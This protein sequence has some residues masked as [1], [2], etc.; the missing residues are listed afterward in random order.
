[1][2]F[3]MMTVKTAADAFMHVCNCL[4]CLE[5]MTYIAWVYRP[6]EFNWF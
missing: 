1:M 2:A 3:A 5:V 6:L 4:N